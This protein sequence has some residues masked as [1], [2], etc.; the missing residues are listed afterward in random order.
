MP[1]RSAVPPVRFAVF[2]D[3]LEKP[4]PVELDA[5][6]VPVLYDSGDD[7]ERAIARVLMARV[8]AYLDGKTSFDDAMR[9]PEYYLPVK[10]SVIPV[11]DDSDS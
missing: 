10:I 3:V 7:A 4:R 6:G 5:Y 1:A 8:Q 9:M 11:E 2:A